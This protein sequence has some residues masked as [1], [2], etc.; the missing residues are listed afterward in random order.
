MKYKL[1][2]GGSQIGKTIEHSGKCDVC[3][4]EGCMVIFDAKTIHGPWGWLCQ[5]CFDTI[6]VGLG[7]GSGQEYHIDS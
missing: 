4:E 3:Q 7:I 5:S 2:R 1:V 6:G